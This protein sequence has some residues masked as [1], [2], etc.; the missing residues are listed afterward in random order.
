MVL[1]QLSL[2]KII[3][4]RYNSFQKRM[5]KECINAYTLSTRMCSHLAQQ[6]LFNFRPLHLYISTNPRT[7]PALIVNRFHQRDKAHTHTHTVMNVN[8]LAFRK[9]DA[10]QSP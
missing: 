6:V 7:N 2:H 10:T 1:P 9:A 3:K 4:I 8:F 5:K